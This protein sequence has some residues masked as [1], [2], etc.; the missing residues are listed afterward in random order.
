MTINEYPIKFG[1]THVLF[2]LLVLI[3]SIFLLNR[4][5]E[6]LIFL[7]SFTVF[8]MFLLFFY[9]IKGMELKEVLL[10]LTLSPLLYLGIYFHYLIFFV[11]LQDILLLG[12]FIYSFYTFKKSENKKTIHLEKAIWIFTIWII[13]I[14]FKR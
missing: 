2:A 6:S 12:L 11:I 7:G 10:F 14:G 5:D 13:L 4:F 1:S 8:L 3:G 9:F